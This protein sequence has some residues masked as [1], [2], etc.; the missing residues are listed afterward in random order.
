MP[1]PL[2]NTLPA[3]MIPALLQSSPWTEHTGLNGL[4]SN[5][6]SVLPWPRSSRKAMLHDSYPRVLQSHIHKC[7]APDNRASG[8]SF[9]QSSWSLYLLFV[10]F[11]FFSCAGH[12]RVWVRYVC[13][14]PVASRAASLSL[15]V[16]T[17]STVSSLG[18]LKH[19]LAP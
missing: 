2:K 10:F 13:G 9:S 12:I 6:V 14:P 7:P 11:A 15:E 18:E 8:F 3:A 1:L 5:Q 4:L 17:V 16:T 19:K